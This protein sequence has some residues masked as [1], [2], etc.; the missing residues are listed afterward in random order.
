MPSSAAAHRL[1]ASTVRYTSASVSSPSA[2]I[3][4]RSSASLPVRKSTGD[5]RLVRPLLERRLDAV[6]AAGVHRQ[7]LAVVAAAP[8]AAERT[9]TAEHRRASRRGRASRCGEELRHQDGKPR[10]RRRAVHHAADLRLAISVRYPLQFGPCSTSRGKTWPPRCS[11]AGDP[12]AAALDRRRP[13]RHVRPAHRRRRGRR[14]AARRARAARPLDRRAAGRQHRRVRDLVPRRRRG[15]ARAAAGR[16]AP[17]RARRALGRRG[18]RRRRCDRAPGDADRARAPSRPR[19]ADEHVGLDRFAQAR[20]ALA[21]QRRQQRPGDRRLPRADADRPRHHDA[22]AALLLRAVGPALPPRG[23]RRHGVDRGLRRRPVL[24]G[25][26]ARRARHERRRRPV[27]L[28]APR[29]VRPRRGARPVTALPDP[30]RRTH[31]AGAPADVARPHGRLGRRPVRDVR[32]DR[33]DGPDGVPPAGPR[34]P[35]SRRDRTADPRRAPRAAAGRRRRR[36]RRRARLPR[37]E[38]D[39]RLRHRRAPTWRSARTLDELRTGDLGRY[40]PDD[41]VFEIVGRRARFVKPF[42]LR[43]D[44]DVVEASLAGDRPRRRRRGRRRTARG[45]RARRRRG[46]DQRRRRGAHAGCPRR[47]SWS[48][49]GR[50]ASRQR[51]GRLRPLGRPPRG[52]VRR[53][54]DRGIRGRRVRDGA[55]TR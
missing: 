9:P 15:R 26:D 4:S 3:R 32:P 24:R 45:V 2:A 44:L 47:R 54:A 43:I 5:A 22:P 23:R 17:R 25:R 52:G 11:L 38:R 13:R 33:G 18:G 28:R 36:R 14:R 51:Q 37:P 50:P 40:H 34:R 48:T 29:S 21:P 8:D 31:G 6:V 1:P 12:G 49:R 7:P 30:G 10:G 27:H 35:P 20:A 46:G 41:D 39:A 53:R 19:P 42:G 16:R 55:R